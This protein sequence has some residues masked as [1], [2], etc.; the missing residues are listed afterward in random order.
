MLQFQKSIIMLQ[1]QFQELL[2]VFKHILLARLDLN[3]YFLLMDHAIYQ[4]SFSMLR[5]ITFWPVQV[6][7][8]P[9]TAV[10]IPGTIPG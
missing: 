3:F 8:E 2:R 6:G 4:K 5:P 10:T 9:K 7:V 1:F